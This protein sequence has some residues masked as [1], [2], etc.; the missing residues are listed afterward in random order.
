MSPD[1]DK[2]Y[3]LVLSARFKFNHL[4]YGGFLI[5]HL[6][7]ICFEKNILSAMH[8]DWGP[9][10]LSLVACYTYH[11]LI[12]LPCKTWFF[13]DCNRNCKNHVLGIIRTLGT[14]N[15]VIYYN[16]LNICFFSLLDLDTLTIM[17]PKI[18]APYLWIRP[19]GLVPLNLAYGLL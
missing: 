15:Q 18:D 5:W 7:F 11:L 9:P 14:S 2:Y 6:V 1:A 8:V 10:H 17:S 4:S 13:K 19:L 16:L 12:P 3:P